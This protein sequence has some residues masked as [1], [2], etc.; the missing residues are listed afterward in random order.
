[1]LCHPPDLVSLVSL[2]LESAPENAHELTL[3]VFEADDPH[4]C[5]LRFELLG[6]ASSPLPPK[7]TELAAK[8]GGE[9]GADQPWFT[10]VANRPGAQGSPDDSLPGKG[11]TVLVVEDNLVNQ[12]LAE[13][14]LRHLGA[15]FRMAPNGKEALQLAS[16]EDFDLILMDIHMPVMDGITATRAIRA[17]PGQKHPYITALTA[18][19]LPGDRERCLQA[20]MDDYLTKP[21]RVDVLAGVISKVAARK[22]TFP[23]RL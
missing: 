18:F 14:C 2:L 7:A 20:G 23:G 17:L 8:L 1:M 15:A 12:R 3:Y 6:T 21:C 11:L 13:E 4:A 10:I 22:K 5:V 16:A 9:S 19:A